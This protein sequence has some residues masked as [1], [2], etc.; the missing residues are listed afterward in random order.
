VDATTIL[1]TTRSKYLH[2]N[3]EANE[4]SQTG[5]TSTSHNTDPS[6]LVHRVDISTENLDSS[7]FTRQSDVKII[8]EINI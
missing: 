1:F 4:M 5:S 8:A 7:C 2:D 3:V 6:L